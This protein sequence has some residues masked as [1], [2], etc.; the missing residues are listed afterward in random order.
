MEDPAENNAPPCF[1]PS[2][3]EGVKMQID[4]EDIIPVPKNVI[5]DIPTFEKIL[6]HFFNADINTKEQF[7]KF[8]REKQREFKV[9]ITPVQLLYVYKILLR[10]KQIDKKTKQEIRFLK[11]KT[12]RG[13]SGVIVVTVLTSPWPKTVEEGYGKEVE[14]DIHK[15]DHFYKPQ[16]TLELGGKY[17]MFSCKYDCWYCPAEPGQPR[18]YAKKE[19]AVARAN[20]N[21][22][23]AVAQFRDRGMTYLVNGHPFDKIELLV[24]GGT[25][26]SYPK[27]YQV[28]FIR[29][30]YYAAN[31]FYDP[32]F[33]MEP[34][35]R[36][37]LEEEIKINEDSLCRIIGLTL[38]T[39][40]D[41]ISPNELKRFRRFGV[42]RVQLGVQHTDDEILKYVNRGCYLKDTV[43]AIKLLKE[44]CFKV[45]IHLMPDLPG[46]DVWRDKT[47]LEKVL[48]DENLQADQWKLY[49]C[50]VLDW[51][52]IKIWYENGKKNIIMQLALTLG[53]FTRNI[54]SQLGKFK[55][56]EEVDQRIYKPYQEQILKH[57][58]INVGKTKKINSTPLYELLIALLPNIH[59]WIRVNRIIRDFPGFY[60]KNDNYREDAR[61]I[62]EREVINRGG[63]T[64]DIRSR[65]VRNNLDGIEN[66]I[67]VVR[68]YYG[69]GGTEYFISFESPDKRII[70]GFLR[71]RLSKE[72]GT[73][74]DELKDTALMRELHVYG[75]V[76]SVND[77]ESG[78]EKTQHMGF[79]KKLIQKAE[80]ISWNEGYKRLAVISG[81]GVRN[82]YRKQGYLDCSGEGNF[83][84]K[85]LNKYPIIFQPCEV[86]NPPDTI[87]LKLDLGIKP[88]YEDYAIEIFLV[89]FTLFVT[90]LRAHSCQKYV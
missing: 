47:M 86:I 75:Q 82:Y 58:F 61:Q 63:F 16:K 46:S 78:E 49:P 54:L 51:T 83:Q 85:D 25:W 64:Q 26:S 24:L 1:T 74:F 71:L 13:L 77:K 23:D 15:S 69:S 21:R 35:E 2:S 52:K 6:G 48:N 72:S 30:L 80:E 19:P 11:S 53:N 8:I 68:K 33:A 42:T 28:E 43:K 87:T 18:S 62:L 81:V 36:K 17:K 76:V 14:G 55:I 66:A 89:L 5:P 40:P 20:Q 70:Y 34:R 56:Q 90:M 32:K 12:V 73:V 79:G 65:E 59:P 41:Q 10:D 39:R 45:D 31:T 67:L 9:G 37:T 4:M 22:F 29:D 60:I 38:E 57:R 88:F 3:K 27:D 50:S 44:N 7:D 84:I